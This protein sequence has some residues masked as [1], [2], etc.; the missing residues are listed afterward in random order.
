MPTNTNSTANAKELRRENNAECKQQFSPR[1]LRPS[2][3]TPVATSTGSGVFKFD[4]GNN[5]VHSSQRP[6]TASSRERLKSEVHRGLL[7]R[8]ISSFKE[9]IK[10]KEVKKE[11]V[12]NRLY[13]SG[14][15][16]DVKFTREAPFSSRQSQ[17]GSEYKTSIDFAIGFVGN[18]GQTE[19]L[20]LLKGHRQ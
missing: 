12:F 9:Q 5:Q 2:A 6:V 16:R 13:S 11:N 15:K 4:P 3:N 10:A 20:S 8:P 19:D 18:I 7:L 1:L 17:A 14:K